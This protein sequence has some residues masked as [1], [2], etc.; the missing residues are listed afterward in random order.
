MPMTDAGVISQKWLRRSFVVLVCMAIVY[1]GVSSWTG[2]AGWTVA[3]EAISARD[4]LILIGL[5]TIGLLIRAAR[6]HY[7][8]SLLGWNVPMS[9]S[10]MTFVA[11]VALT[12]TPGK[13]GEVVKAALLRTR[14]NVSLSQGA[15]VLL[16]E[17]LG[18]LLAVIV[19][20][21]GGL[22]VFA[23]LKIYVLASIALISG[24]VL[25]ILHPRASQSVLD[26]AIRVS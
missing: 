10:V 16:I 15:A 20:A 21:T 6:W 23:D 14:H 11:S 9:H 3:V 17:R 22:T 4:V 1:V 19:L 25:L 18:D 5:I 26:P 7:Y 2:R 24:V 13:T 12:A 8:I